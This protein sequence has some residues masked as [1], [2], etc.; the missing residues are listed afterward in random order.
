MIEQIINLK[1]SNQNIDALNLINDVSNLDAFPN[2][3][4][5][6][7]VILAD[8]GEF[9]FALETYKNIKRKDENTKKSLSSFR[10]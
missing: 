5:Q 7:V 6:K 4:T 2:I 9:D 10:K 1:N 8:L 3:L